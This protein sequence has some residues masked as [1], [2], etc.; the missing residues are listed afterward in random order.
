MNYGLPYHDSYLLYL[1]TEVHMANNS[2]Y[3]DK[4]CNYK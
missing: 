1:P 2:L 4:T 3:P